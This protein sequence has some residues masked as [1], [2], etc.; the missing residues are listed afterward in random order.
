MSPSSLHVENQR[1]WDPSR[2][3]EAH[4]SQAAWQQEKLLFLSETHSEGA[5]QPVQKLLQSLREEEE[6]H[7]MLLAKMF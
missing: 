2:G 1:G 6:K 5:A 7:F 4:Y 3:K